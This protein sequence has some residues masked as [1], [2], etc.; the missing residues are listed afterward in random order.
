VTALSGAVLGGVALV[1]AATVAGAWLVRRRP[2][3]RQSWFAAAAGL[4]LII[5]GL[6][7]LPDA[8]ADAQEAGVW[9]PLVPMAAAAAF[10][11][12]GLAARVGCACGEHRELVAGA[13]MAVALAMHRFLEG[14]AIALTG[15]AAVAL[16]L[17]AHAFGEGLATGSLLSGQPRRRV[18]GCLALMCVSPVLGAVVADAFPVP[19]VAEPVLVATA[20]G[21]LAQAALVSLRAAFRGLRPRQLLV[22]RPAAVTATAAVVTVLVVYGAG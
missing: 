9:P 11:A 15:S 3:Q 4:L 1:A 12:A 19:E 10:V 16:A 22:S 13:G 5:A 8:W 2:G 18:A 20:A 21:V 7:L 6:H 17:A 14:A